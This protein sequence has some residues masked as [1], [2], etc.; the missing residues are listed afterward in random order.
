M[1]NQ[2]QAT[3][4]AHQFQIDGELSAITPYGSGHIARYIAHLAIVTGIAP[5]ILIEEDDR[6]LATLDA[7]ASDMYRRMQGKR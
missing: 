3:S 6:M 2:P 1:P 4:A 5:S 7:E